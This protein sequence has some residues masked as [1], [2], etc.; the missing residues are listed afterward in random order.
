M[1][2]GIAAEPKLVQVPKKGKVG[3]GIRLCTRNWNN[4]AFWG[5]SAELRACNGENCRLR[6]RPRSAA[7]C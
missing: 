7:P 2:R 4:I 1:L 3:K 6:V 5:W